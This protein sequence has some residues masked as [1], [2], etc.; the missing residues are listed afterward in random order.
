MSWL[1]EL[2][3]DE[4]GFVVSSEAVIVGTVGVLGATVGLDA[5]SESVNSELQDF[6]KALRGL[7]QSYSVV[8]RRSTRSWVARSWY[9]ESSGTE[10]VSDVSKIETR[11][12]TEPQTYEPTRSQD[13]LRQ[14][15]LAE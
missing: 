1:Q 4:R 14:R 12:S 10:D 3:S 8:E 11:G 7:N 15:V 2:L 6:A 5:A 13:S 9:Q